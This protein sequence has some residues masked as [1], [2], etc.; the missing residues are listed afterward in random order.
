MKTNGSSKTRREAV[1]EVPQA[2]VLRPL[3]FN[4]FIFVKDTQE[5]C[6]YAEDSIIYACDSNIERCP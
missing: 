1:I 5:V 2:S 6:N 3:L 4:L